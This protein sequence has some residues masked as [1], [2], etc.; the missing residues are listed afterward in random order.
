[1]NSTHPRAHPLLGLALLACSYRGPRGTT[2]P[3]E[4]PRATSAQAAG[5][6]KAEPEVRGLPLIANASEQAATQLTEPYPKGR[7]RLVSSAQL[8]RTLFWFS[9]ILIRHRDVPPQL[10]SFSVP[11]WFSA[12]PAPERDR[13]QALKLAESIRGQLEAD[14]GRFSALARE[15]SEDLVSRSTGGARGGVRA[16]D[17]ERWP[18]VLDALVTLKPGEVSRVVETEYGFHVLLRQATPEQDTVSGER[19]VIGHDDAPWLGTYLAR[20]TVN[21]RS[22]EEAS[23]LAQSLYEQARQAP[24]TFGNWINV[25]SEHVDALRGGD[26]G[27]WSTREATPW[28]R[29]VEA[30]RHLEVGQIA[31]PLESLLGFEILRRV[32][33]RPRAQLAARGIRFPFDT[34]RARGEGAPDG[35]FQQAQEVLALLRDEPSRF[36]ELQAKQ[37]AMPPWSWVEGVEAAPIEVAL[38][39][40]APGQIGTEP[41]R[42]DSLSSYLVLQRLAPT[43]VS[44]PAAL[45]VLFDLP[46]DAEPDVTYL[47]SEALDA[48]SLHQVFGEALQ[49]TAGKG[50]HGAE[51]Q[52]ISELIQGFKDQLQAGEIVAL[53]AQLQSRSRALLGDALFADF[54]REWRRRIEKAAM[55]R[56]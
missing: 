56:E 27:Q 21:H 29:E 4:A 14:S 17:L 13:V 30:L 48:T 34:S 31:P 55:D 45:P 35:V 22:R 28:P 16:L 51:V 18:A 41:V 1:M 36:D 15:Y 9:H 6:A 49:A 54:E 50:G 37:D 43:Q 52:A 7:W 46:S 53:L 8:A 32:P 12:P 40:L 47:V 19:L 10:V 44:T 42:V 5:P 26:L 33:N 39:T 23:A 11:F 25:R 2:P 20:G 38:R 24:E 3:E